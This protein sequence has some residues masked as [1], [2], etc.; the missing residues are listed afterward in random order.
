MENFKRITG[1]EESL[2]ISCV[3]REKDRKVER[4]YVFIMKV[5]II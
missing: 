1:G 2:V 4:S 3:A 5:V